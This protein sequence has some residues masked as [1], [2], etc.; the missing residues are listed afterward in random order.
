MVPQKTPQA[1][2]QA[3]IRLLD[4]P[5]L[6][7]RYGTASRTRIEQDLNWPHVAEMFEQLYEAARVRYTRRHPK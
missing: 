7:A 1:L 6:R 4:S 2:A 3:V 5:D